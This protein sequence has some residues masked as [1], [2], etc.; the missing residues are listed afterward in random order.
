MCIRDSYDI[1]ESSNRV[2]STLKLTAGAGYG[3]KILKKIPGVLLS[4]A[5]PSS[6]FSLSFVECKSSKRVFYDI[7]K[8]S[9]HV[10]SFL[11]LTAG[12]GYEREIPQKIPGVLLSSAYPSSYFSL[13]FVECETSRIL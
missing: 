2:C 10:F 12:V 13:S 3:R 5:Q 8:S 6:Y 9:N 7:F 4:T 1:F 11:K